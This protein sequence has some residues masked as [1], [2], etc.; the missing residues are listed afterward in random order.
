M[1]QAVPCNRSLFRLSML[2]CSLMLAMGA[3]SY[4]QDQASPASGTES[5]RTYAIPEGPL[6]GTLR[7]ISRVSGRQISFETRDVQ[8]VRAPALNGSRHVIAAVQ[9]VI[10]GSGLSMTTLANGN[11]HVFVPQLGTVT[12]TATRGEAETGFKAS[13]SETATRSGA[14]LLDV[15]QAVTVVTAKVLETQQALTIQDALQN[16][17]GV[18][19]RESTQGPSGFTIRGFSQTSALSNGIASP[20][21]ANTDIAGVERIEVLKGPQAILAGNDSLGGAVNIVIKK[22]TAETVRDIGLQ[23]GTHADKRADVDFSG[24]LTDDKRLS[25]RLLGAVARADRS[26]AGFDGRESDYAMASI[27]WKDEATDIT[28]GVSYSNQ[29]NPANRYTFALTGDVQPIPDMRMG[30]AHSGFGVEN[31]ELFYSLEHSFAPWITVI[32]RMQRSLNTRDINVFATRFPASVANMILGMANTNNIWDYRTTSGDHYVRMN[33]ETGPLLH[34]LSTGVNHSTED[35]SALSYQQGLFGV[36]VFVPVYQEGQFDFQPYSRDTDLFSHYS[37]TREQRGLFIQDLINVGDWNL[38]LGLRRT[39]YESGPN[40]TENLLTGVVTTTTKS[41]QKKTTPNAG[42]VYNLTP[43]VS[44]YASYAEGFLP[45]FGI[46][47]PN[48]AGG[49]D[50]PPMD[51]KNQELGIKTES[52]DGAFSWSSAVFQL[53]QSNRL[54]FNNAGQC[55]DMRDGTRVR[56]FETE[57][58]GRF[59]PGLNLIASY[60]YKKTED[61]GNST[62]LPVAEPRHQ[63]TL[64]ST[65]DFQSGAMQGFGVALGVTAHSEARVGTFASD[66]MVPGGARVDVGAS[67][68]R[69]DWSVRLGI[70]NLFDRDL[71]GYSSSALYVP[72]MEGRTMTVTFRKS[73]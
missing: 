72:V 6:A 5:S 42:L 19:A 50:Y 29:F 58:A 37:A 68:A 32:S 28:T 71:Y 2:C 27:R 64:W 54:Q 63:A 46:T 47:T 17:A 22:P 25:Y 44:M 57:A 35:S 24:A 69:D 7:E 21:A 34:K 45:Q 51:T 14:N 1:S 43:N 8:D 13:S 65:Y 59:L 10:A 18:V 61:V 66:P 53:Q 33:F 39:T 4:A 15:P 60:T 23:Y 56:G 11:L 41:S 67:Y 52:L 55:Y 26:D 12:V 49:N 30:H 48:C 20:F 70:K 62:M 36:T 31:R 38:L 9:E 16:V 40:S 3:P 73:F